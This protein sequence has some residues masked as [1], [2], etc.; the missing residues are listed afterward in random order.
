MTHRIGPLSMDLIV[1]EPTFSLVSMCF[2]YSWT[3]IMRRVSLS[4][5]FQ[6]MRDQTQNTAHPRPNHQEEKDPRQRGR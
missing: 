6:A 4:Q 3:V 2:A 5:K 1:Y